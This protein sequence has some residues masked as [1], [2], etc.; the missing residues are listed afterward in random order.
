MTAYNGLSDVELTVL[1]KD[2]D[3][4]AYSVIYQRYWA[5]LF[6]HA[7]RMLQDEEQA[8]DVIQDLFTFVWANTAELDIR[9]SI[10]SYL[11]AAL[12]NRILKIFRH[13]KVARKYMDM[14][15]DMELH[16]Q[17][18]T[19]ENMRE[20]ELAALIERE[21]SMLP[22]KMRE[23]F[24]L[25]RKAHLSYKQIAEETNVSEGT[26]K[27]QVYNALKVLRARL[28][29]LFFTGLMKIILFFFG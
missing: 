27:K 3:H 5:V 12:R 10:S 2:G 21:V 20:K 29:M 26:V 25:S 24:E 4:Y 14:L 18:P 1:L 15:P 28:G 17:N 9:T 23:I 16:G 6:R 13:E 11:Y 8:A 19:D 7:R 22:P